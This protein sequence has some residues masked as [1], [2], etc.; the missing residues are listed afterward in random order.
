MR[1]HELE[2]VAR[3][4]VPAGKG[5]LAADES[6]PTIKKRFEHIGLESTEET[7]RVY[8]EL[9]FTT[10]GIE[11]SISGVIL[12]DETIR[13]TAADNTPFVDLL[14]E[15]GIMPGIKVDRGAADLAGFT[16]EKITG[17]PCRNRRWKPG[18]AIRKC[19]RLPR[20]NSFTAPAATAPHGSASIIR[21]WSCRH[22]KNRP[23][24][25]YDERPLD[26]PPSEFGGRNL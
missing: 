4:L 25:Q 24:L 22:L 19:Y 6:F 5:I 15:R 18:E 11:E 14:Y 9:L 23:D 16:G 12:F 1:L 26:R 2:S 13:Q 3:S 20:N 8:R 21:R 17:G 10:V 7:R